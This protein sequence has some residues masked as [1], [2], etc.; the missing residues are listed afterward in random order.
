MHG[1]KIELESVI[2]MKEDR[3]RSMKKRKHIHAFH[4]TDLL[5]LA[6][7][8]IGVCVFVLVPFLDV[9]RRS[10]TNVVGSKFVGVENY[11]TVAGNLA[12]RTAVT[13]TL[14]FMVLAIPFL[15]IVSLLLA[16]MLNSKIKAGN[17]FKTAYLMPMAI[18][19][20]SVVLILRAAFYKNGFFSVIAE[21]FG[22]SNKNWMMTKYSLLVLVGCYVWRNLGYNVVLW[23]A[24]LSGI[25]PSIDEAAQV[26]GAN[27]FQRFFQ[28]KLP[29]LLPSL[30]MITVM[31][32]LNSFKVFRE[33]YLIGGDYP[34]KH[35]YLIQ[36]VFNNWFRELSLDKMAAGA[37][38]VCLVIMCLIILLQ[39]VWNKDEPAE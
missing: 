23:L 12:F 10:F 13:N 14:E 25:N 37:V 29:N 24:G 22:I 31:A 28:I 35:M 2:Y 34:E 32:L 1:R 5:Y 17:L 11:K 7:S 6:P 4:P 30:Y 3:R 15:I 38:L 39:H 26:D 20:A 19:V 9:I 27:A 16:L 8:F 18:P 33:G 21:Y 36:H